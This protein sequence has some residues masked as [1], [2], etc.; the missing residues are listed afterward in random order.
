MEGRATGHDGVRD[1]RMRQFEVIDAHVEPQAFERLDDDRVAVRVHQV[2]REAKSQQLL[3]DHHV[4][5]V[6]TFQEG[7][8]A[9]LDVGQES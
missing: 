7:L 4:R 6:L 2:V 1:Y 3:V 9:R 8:I 5:H